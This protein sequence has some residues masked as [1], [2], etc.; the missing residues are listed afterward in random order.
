MRQIVQH[1]VLRLLRQGRSFIY[2]HAPVLNQNVLKQAIRAKKSI[3]VDLSVNAKGKIYIGHPMSYYTYKYLPAPRNASL[4]NVIKK[5]EKA[6]LFLV[7][8]V[9]DKRALP[10]VKK[11]V[12][13]YGHEHCLV[14]AWVD[15]LDFSPYPD[16]IIIQPHWK[17]ETLPL[18]LLER[19]SGETKVPLMLSCRGLTLKRLQKEKQ[20]ILRTITKLSGSNVI[21]I[22]FALHD[23]AVPPKGIMKSITQQGLLP[24][25]HID[26]IPKSKLPTQY[27][28]YSDNIVRVSKV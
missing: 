1:R 21:A 13:K 16:E 5:A 18:K 11:I 14:H 12:Q 24:L 4:A 6:K 7:L 20:Q 3:E 26:A 15:A 25:L 9:K 28:G 2:F 17:Q 19:L 10:R 23:R 22:S 27:I 8:D